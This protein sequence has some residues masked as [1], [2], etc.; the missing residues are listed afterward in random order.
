MYCLSSSSLLSASC[1]AFPP[2]RLHSRPV[3]FHTSKQHH[4]DVLYTHT[5][6]LS[7]SH[8]YA[9]TDT[10]TCSTF[11]MQVALQTHLSLLKSKHTHTHVCKHT[12]TCTNAVIQTQTHTV[13]HSYTL[14]PQFRERRN[15]TNLSRSVSPIHYRHYNPA[16][17]RCDQPP[18]RN[19]SSPRCV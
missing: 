6:N 15:S 10:Y 4:T 7:H 13:C 5:A 17:L 11:S 19:P 9:P 14:P 2:P 8:I 18:I 12:H 3:V 1:S 16:H